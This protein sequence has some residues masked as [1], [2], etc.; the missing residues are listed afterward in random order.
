LPFKRRP[1]IR[2]FIAIALALAVLSGEA[3]ADLVTY[4]MT[5]IVLDP[6]QAVS[7]TGGFAPSPVSPGDQMTWTLQYDRATPGTFNYAFTPFGPIFGNVY[8]PAS[9]VIANLVDQT[10]GLHFIM[11]PAASL[12]SDLT[13][14]N[15][16]I[17]GFLLAGDQGLVSGP[18]GIPCQTFLTLLGPSSGFSTLDLSQLSLD[19]AGIQMTLP[20]GAFSDLSYD[21]V[22]DAT[23][24]LLSFDI[25][26]TSLS[27]ASAPE[28]GS[29]TLVVLAALG[30]VARRV[31]SRPRHGKDHIHRGPA[32]D[33][34]V[35]F[36]SPCP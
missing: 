13:V 16:P 20:Y 18:G 1:P 21:G 36:G 31:P 33:P 9:P 23:G 11:P 29:L 34:P 5:G 6:V 19:Q 35:P 26:V 12:Q 8:T 7:P 15:A 25:Q 28:P 14:L 3:I 27:V 22:P 17:G 4:N 32:V 30:L 24:N 2:L 10:T